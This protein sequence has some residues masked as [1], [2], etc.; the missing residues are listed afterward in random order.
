MSVI[1]SVATLSDEVKIASVSAL[2]L[3]ALECS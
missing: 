3:I 2:C 1:R